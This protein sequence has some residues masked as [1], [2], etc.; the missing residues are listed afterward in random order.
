[1]GEIVNLKQMKKRLA[2]AQEAREAQEN[3]VR[4]GRTGAQKLNDR[5]EAAL[6]NS[7][8]DAKH[9]DRAPDEPADAE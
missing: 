9:R 6:R 3:R 5:R 7:L 2:R 1:M 8:L 4:F